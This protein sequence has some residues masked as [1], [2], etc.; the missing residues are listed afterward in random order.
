[1]AFSCQ[2]S[3]QI[4]AF[5]VRLSAKMPRNDRLDDNAVDSA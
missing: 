1:M 2:I 5:S 3:I 4:S